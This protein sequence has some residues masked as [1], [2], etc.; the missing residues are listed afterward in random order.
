MR[1]IFGGRYLWSQRNAESINRAASYFQQAVREDASFALAYSGLSD[2]YWVGWGAKVDLPLADEYAQKAVALQRDL[3]EA[4][5]SLGI[6]RLNEYK[7]SDAERELTRAIE[8]NPNYAMAPSL[9]LG[10]PAQCR[11]PDRRPQR[12]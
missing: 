7:M 1:L 12:E 2:C 9:L 5:A 6:V 4:H 3:A 11:P 10:L 8:L